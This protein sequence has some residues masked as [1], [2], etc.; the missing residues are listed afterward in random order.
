M[1][2][3]L[4]T[5]TDDQLRALIQQ[6]D[7]IH[8]LESN[9][10]SDSRADIVNP[11]SGARGS[12][13]ITSNGA[14]SKSP[15]FGVQPSNGTPED[16]ARTGRDYYAAMFQ[17]YNGDPTKAAVAYNWGPGNAD[18]WIANGMKMSDLPDE[19][20]KYL[21]NHEKN[22]P[23]QPAQKVAPAAQIA[24]PALPQPSKVEMTIA[25]EPAADTPDYTPIGRIQQGV[26]SGLGGMA[27]AGVKGLA[28]LQGKAGDTQGAQANNELVQQAE[29]AQAARDREFALKAQMAGAE[30][31]KTDWY[32]V[33]GKMIP[34]F[35]I[36][37]FG[38][39]S[40]LGSAAEGGLQGFIQGAADTQPGDSYLESAARGAAFGGA[41]GGAL[42]AVA[43]VFRG[44]DLSPEAQLLK[45][46][47]VTLTPG[48]LGS[49]K[50]GKI[51][52]DI[53]Q[54]ATSW[55]IVGP[56]IGD[57]R[58]ASVHE[59][60]DA[61]LNRALAPIGESITPGQPIREALQE[62]KD[63]LSAAYQSI[64]PHLTF[65]DD[66][67]YTASMQNVLTQQAR[68]PQ[69]LRDE[70]DNFMTDYIRNQSVIGPN[71]V[72]VLT[73][74]ALKTAE[75]ALG[76][77]AK[78]FMSS[79][80]A[81]QRKLGNLY[82]DTLT[83]FRAA[84]QRQ[85][86]Q[87]AQ[88]LQ[89]INNGFGIYAIMRNAGKKVMNPENP[90]MAGQLQ[91]AVRNNAGGVDKEAFALGNARLQDLSDAGVKTLGQ[92][93]PDSGT[94]ARLMMGAGILGG[95]GIPMLMAN[96]GLAVGVGGLAAGYGTEAGR[97]ALFAMLARRP[98]FARQ[99]ADM[100]QSGAGPAGGLAGI[101]S[102]RQ[103]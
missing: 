34:S 94:A 30:P 57:A 99:L 8:K 78:Q 21:L 28:W 79:T 44:A 4:S 61:G 18:K 77:Q 55:P 19:T 42:G 91:N 96:P 84:L 98:E 64:L 3:D 69:Q 9:G 83:N 86:P 47:G 10:A 92:T 40:V 73:G 80:D 63:K 23:S 16:D 29:E 59:M 31:G 7:S 93:V 32:Q 26:M 20:L 53:E 62:T 88:R 85:N 52:N 37:G 5:L 95:T 71:G 74:D 76:Q 35:L 17:R 66:P 50:T 48:M 68:L 82:R 43:R 100:V 27:R 33:G 89:D 11:A 12:M 2:L 25:E 54:K 1:A 67:A 41:A 90:I 72:P 97:K 56:L 24:Q 75:S 22:A 60:N 103:Q 58:R 46:E 87:Y 65:A 6:Q 101:L 13:Q 39:R 38:A 70:F 45:N 36:P 14:G 102:G 15:G 51:I 49:G 81:F